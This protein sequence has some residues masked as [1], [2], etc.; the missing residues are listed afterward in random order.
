MVLAVDREEVGDDGVHAATRFTEKT[1]VPVEPAVRMTEAL[2]R[3]A[4]TGKIPADD[5]ARCREYLDRY[6]TP[7]ARAWAAR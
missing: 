7:E 6:G 2:D 4:E 1:G 3:L 5:L